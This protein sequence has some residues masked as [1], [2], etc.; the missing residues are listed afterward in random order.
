MNVEIATTKNNATADSCLPLEIWQ[1]SLLAIDIATG[2]VNWVRQVE[3]LDAWTIACGLPG[4]PQTSPNCPQ[5]PG[6][7]A[8]FGIAPK[9]VR[10]GQKTQ[11]PNGEDIIVAGQKNGNLYAMSAR[12]GETLWATVTGPE[13]LLGGLSWGI[14]V[15]EQR[16]YFNQLNSDKK[17]W[18]LQPSNR[19]ING[20]AYGAVSLSS[21]AILWE[22]AAI[23]S[24]VAFG[25]PS[26]VGD[27][28]ISNA[29][30]E[31]IAGQLTVKPGALD[32]LDR[33]TGN[34]LHEVAVDASNHGGFAVQDKYLLF[35]TGYQGYNGT[36]SLYVMK[37]ER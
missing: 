11:T 2:F 6:P 19:T 9:F 18:R 13:G 14:A 31:S 17:S 22:T 33:R 7:D 24:G 28:V 1:D 10:A 25:P 30:A 34:I 26:V 23:G 4:S 27:I 3:P 16:V 5:I 20:S 37:V 12:T 32:V 29:P 36:G 15:D 35:G 21:G 8:D